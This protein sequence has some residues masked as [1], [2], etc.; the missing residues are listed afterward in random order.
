M[1]ESPDPFSDFSNVE[2]TFRLDPAPPW[3]QH[4][5]VP[6][7]TK[8][9]PE[10][11]VT[12]LL[13]HTQLA[14]VRFMRH[15]RSVRRLISREAMQRL[16]QIEVEWDP[17]VEELIIHEVA[18]WRQG[19]KRSFADRRRFMLRQRE[20]GL[21]QHL[22]H[23][24]MSAILV[25]DDVRVD[26]CIELEFSVHAQAR[27][28]GEKFDAIYATE[29]PLVTGLWE[30]AVHLPKEH[31]FT[32]RSIPPTLKMEERDEPATGDLVRYF[33]GTQ[34]KAAE[35]DGGTP[36]WVIPHGHFH[37]S[38]YASWSEVARCVGDAW[39]SV[40]KEH[41]TLTALAAEL[42]ADQSSALDKAQSII[43]WV[44]E[45]VRYLG[46]VGGAGGLKPNPPQI[47]QD[48]RYGDCKDK[49]L[50]LC[51]LLNLA[52]IPAEPILVHTVRR[53]A[54][55]SSLP[56]LGAFDHV[57]ATF[58]IEGQRG[59]VDA[60]CSGDG[61]GPLERCMPDYGFGLVVN[62]ASTELMP[63]PYLTPDRTSMRVTEDFHL[64]RKLPESYVDWRIEATGWDANGL[65]SRLASVGG[66]TFAKVEADDLRQ[67]FH[68]AKSVMPAMWTDDLKDNRI[69]VWGRT[70]FSEWATQ[71]GTT[72][73]FQYRP[74]WV[75]HSISAPPREEKRSYAFALSY[76]VRIQHVIRVHAE[77]HSF[78]QRILLK[79]NCPWFQA[80]TKIER[81]TKQTVEA[82]YA[83]VSLLPDLESAA[84]GSYWTQ[85]D[86][87]VGNQLGITLAIDWKGPT[88]CKLPED[89]AGRLPPPVD[90]T[91]VS[92][93]QISLDAEENKHDWLHRVR[94]AQH[95][96]WEN[97]KRATWSPAYRS[98]A[99]ILLG[100]GAFITIGI[101]T[102]DKGKKSQQPARS[103]AEIVR[104]MPTGRQVA[105]AYA[106]K[107]VERALEEGDL[108]AAVGHLEQ[109]QLKTSD[110]APL[111]AA[112]GRL[113][114]LY[115][116]VAFAR[117]R[118]TEALRLSPNYPLAKVTSGEIK[119]HEE[120]AMAEAESI[121]DALNK[122]NPD[123]APGWSLSAEVQIQ[124]GRLALAEQAAQKAI[125][126]APRDMHA[127]R[128]MMNVHGA[129]KNTTSQLQVA[130][131]G[132]KDFPRRAFFDRW[133][134]VHHQN[135]GRLQEAIPHAR[136]AA[137]REPQNPRY[138]AQ[139]AELLAKAGQ[140]AESLN[141]ADDLRLNQPDDPTIRHAIG[142]VYG[143]AGNYG[144][145]V[146]SLQIAV[147]KEPTAQR[148]NDFG[149]SLLT[150]GRNEASIGEFQAAIEMDPTL[151]VAWENLVTAYKAT[152]QTAKQEAAEAKVQE[153]KSR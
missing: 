71:A 87:T 143:L 30:V 99:A 131:Q 136:E 40:P 9:Q 75:Y 113:A 119:L 49:T 114:W 105:T 6:W 39:A 4:L 145:S 10:D 140:K 100:F 19:V 146:E 62:S 25:L 125:S 96:M 91:E 74:R 32:W 36:S 64:H 57:I 81:L 20:S 41:E 52:G 34:E 43:H 142:I 11:H 88:K 56:G 3:V 22:V 97:V 37:F 12:L 101:V 108:L 16:S 24:R 94:F 26:D 127:R 150:G 38:G 68:D 53:Q 130:T 120:N 118:I 128:V 144:R 65:R 72:R 80:S 59:F 147:L 13:S 29:R 124:Q 2:A 117:K 85:L 63:I 121:A 48:R 129:Q 58:M 106:V 139:L 15:E 27:L 98:V 60:T 141:L 51:T 66:E 151:L 73:V 109:L 70:A 42:T 47:V 93:P 77:K 78:V 133:L 5:D 107:E 103:I 79:S 28:E 137:K 134:A 33:R 135:A 8:P 104:S 138:L 95:S 35:L 7:D 76:P 61:G 90:E 67:H 1:N 69:I 148:H 102:G 111:A 116:D 83:Y 86:D 123:F 44:Q 82:S 18:I 115:G 112:Q 149:Y 92:Q 152:G 126:L 122:D 153:L 23:G 55:K 89:I 17:A 31:Y 132:S 54:I 45:K 21:D 46:M 14:P 84:V 50:L 110:G